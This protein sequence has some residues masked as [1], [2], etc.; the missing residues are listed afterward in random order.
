M[1][2]ERNLKFAL[3]KFAKEINS[4]RPTNDQ[5]FAIFHLEA[6]DWP[7]I[8]DCATTKNRFLRLTQGV[9]LRQGRLRRT[10]NKSEALATNLLVSI[11]C[12]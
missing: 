2:C 1:E 9:S 7:Q 12:V 4:P 3:H 6:S 11:L 5:F 8:N 10:I